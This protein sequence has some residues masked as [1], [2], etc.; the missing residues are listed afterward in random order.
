MINEL[1]ATL[2]P[3][4]WDV[5]GNALAQRPYAEVVGLM[6]KLQSQ[7]A[8]Q[9]APAPTSEVPTQGEKNG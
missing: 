1:T 3:Q 6:S 9:G 5:I 2:F 7:L 8:G 4:E